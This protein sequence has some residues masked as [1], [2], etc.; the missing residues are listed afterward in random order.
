[1]I[2]LALKEANFFF[3]AFFTFEAIIKILGYG[4]KY[5]WYVNWNKFDFIIVSFSL[6]A[7]DDNWLDDIGI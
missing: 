7:L 4:F 1:M 6:I 3:T 2:N 5:Y